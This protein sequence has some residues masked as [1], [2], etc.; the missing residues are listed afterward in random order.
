[1]NAPAYNDWSEANQRYLVTQFARLKARLAGE[2]SIAEQ[3]SVVDSRA[4]LP[5]PAAIDR[6][7]HNFGLSPF[8]RDVLL[9]CAGAEMDSK[10]ASL[11]ATAQGNA[12]HT[13]AT[14][15]LALALLNDPHWSALAPT[16]P[17]RRWRLIATTD[18]KSLVDTRLRI[19]ERVLHFLA[20]VNYLDTRLEPLLRSRAQAAA[21]ADAQLGIANSALETLRG[22]AAPYP[23]IQLIG[24]LFFI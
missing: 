6:L 15:S 22:R 16:S 19:D 9:L 24:F 7:V 20:G 17:L 5:A 1:M 10:L 11:C 8:E 12:Q 4:A 18:E 3:A 13:Y 2:E 23:I 14:F 21:M